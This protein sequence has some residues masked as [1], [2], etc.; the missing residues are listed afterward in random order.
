MI[1]N[2][3]KRIKIIFY[4]TIILLNLS[5]VKPKDNSSLNDREKNDWYKRMINKPVYSMNFELLPALSDDFILRFHRYEYY[6]GSLE[7]VLTIRK[8]DGEY[9]LQL[10]H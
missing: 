9:Y 5:C 7:Y 2:N 8:K 6:G 1:G 3:S 4:L 10:I